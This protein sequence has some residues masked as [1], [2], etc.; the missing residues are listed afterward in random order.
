MHQGPNHQ[1]C[2]MVVNEGDKDGINDKLLALEMEEA[3]CEDE[4]QLLMM[5]LCNFN[6]NHHNH[7]VKVNPR[8]S[9]FDFG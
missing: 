4:G 3:E 6:T 1:L 8:S 9:S 2:V 7:P 5:G